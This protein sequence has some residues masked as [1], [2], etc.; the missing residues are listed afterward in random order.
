[1]TNKLFLGDSYSSH[2]A[3]DIVS[4]HQ[5][6]EQF[7]LILAE[8]YFYPESGGQPAD[9]GFIGE[10]AVIDVQQR[11]E[12]I[13]HILGSDP[14]EGELTAILDWSRRY[15]H[16][17]QHSGQHML[18]AAFAQIMAAD[19]LSFHLGESDST[20]DL[21][22]A[23]PTAA[24]ISEIEDLCSQWIAVNMPIE[25]KFISRAEFDQLSLRKKSLPD[26]VE[27]PIRII[28]IGDIDTSHCGG[29]HLASSSELQ[30][31]KIT[32]LEKI[33]DATRVH[34]L[35]GQRAIEDY[36]NKHNSI[37]AIAESLTCATADL[38]SVIEKMQQTGK[39][40][41]SSLRKANQELA[42]LR[43]EADIAKA[44]QAGKWKHICSRYD[45]LD[46]KELKSLAGQITAT[47]QA[48]LFCGVS[49]AEDRGLVVLAAGSDYD[50]DLGEVL[51]QLLPLISGKGGGRGNFAQGMGEPDNLDQLL[52]NAANIFGAME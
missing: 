15:D 26:H 22:C 36:R 10:A 18:T 48:M 8:T 41:Y 50:G 37:S 32:G 16:M 49:R 19:T 38:E 5:V 1:V 33:Q 23:N 21:N 13:I 24:Q 6:E 34:F 2:F 52:D 45:G 9:G 35:A 30:L 11:G 44:E 3:A 46:S 39:D 47:E 17:L 29:T 20:I 51:R 27:E 28:T 25:I 7:E 31:I 40:N 4:K 14:G 43:A 12:D 42:S